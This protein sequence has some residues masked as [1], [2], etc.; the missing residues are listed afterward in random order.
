MYEVLL[1]DQARCF[2]EE[3]S[4]SQ[5]RRLDRCCDRL[6]ADPRRHPNIRPLKGK[7]AGHWRYRVGDYR[8]VYRTDENER[9]VIVL[10]IAHRGSVYE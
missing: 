8:V 10:I 9:V 6:G 1:S 7:L 2:F 3:A 5:Q 4:A